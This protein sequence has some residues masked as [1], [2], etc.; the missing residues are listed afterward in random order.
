MDV[1]QDPAGAIVMGSI[2]VQEQGCAATQPAEAAAA[3][4]AAAEACTGEAAEEK[5]QPYSLAGKAAPGTSRRKRK[6]AN[7]SPCRP[8]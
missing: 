4:Q 5:Q 3:A 2:G 7:L 6:S 8:L 1:K